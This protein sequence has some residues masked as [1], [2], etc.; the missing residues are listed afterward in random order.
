MEVATATYL[1]AAPTRKRKIRESI[2]RRLDSRPNVEAASP[3]WY[4]GRDAFCFKAWNETA[5]NR[6]CGGGDARERML[7]DKAVTLL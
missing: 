2:A 1:T 7:V 5:G 6:S 4:S 3:D